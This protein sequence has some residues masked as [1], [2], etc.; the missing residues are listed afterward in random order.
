MGNT[1]RCLEKGFDPILEN[2]LIKELAEKY[3]KTPGQIVLNWAKQRR[4]CI[5]AK[6]SKITRI[7]ENMGAFD[8]DIS[9]EDTE[10]INGLN[11]NMRMFDPVYGSFSITYPCFS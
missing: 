1:Q 2:S 8:F 5:L 3:S 9:K 4:H 6:T 7:K 11:K 10:A